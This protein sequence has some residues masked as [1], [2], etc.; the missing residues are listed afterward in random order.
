MATLEGF[1]VYAALTPDDDL[2]A[3]RMCYEAALQHARDVDVDVEAL[4]DNEKCSMYIYAMALHLYEN[5]GLSVSSTIYGAD[6]VVKNIK[7][8][9][10]LELVYSPPNLRARG[11]LSDGAG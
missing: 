4:A 8:R 7:A 11:R 2:A 9:M 10:R 6:E 5:R 3:A 1:A